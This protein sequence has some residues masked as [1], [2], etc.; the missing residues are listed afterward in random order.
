MVM[1]YLTSILYILV[2]T[3]IKINWDCFFFFWRGWG[4]GSWLHEQHQ[5]LTDINTTLILVCGTVLYLPMKGY[6]DI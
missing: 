6:I 5:L 4:A 3:T 2:F 1:E